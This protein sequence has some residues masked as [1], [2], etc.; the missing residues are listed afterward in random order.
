MPFLHRPSHFGSRLTVE[1]LENVGIT[2][3]KTSVLSQQECTLKPNSHNQHSNC[4]DLTGRRFLLE[5][6]IS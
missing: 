3:L 4:S 5:P 6:P 1:K 2:D